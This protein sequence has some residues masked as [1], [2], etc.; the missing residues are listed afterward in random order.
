MI[1]NK[2]IE[3]IRKMAKVAQAESD[4]MHSLEEHSSSAYYRGKAVAFGEIAFM[5]ENGIPFNQGG[6]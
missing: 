1:S 6:E 5:A 2:E 4:R 3:A